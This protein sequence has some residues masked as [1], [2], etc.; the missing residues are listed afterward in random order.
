MWGILKGRE[1]ALDEY[2]L[3]KAPERALFFTLSHWFEN[4]PVAIKQN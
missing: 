1:V 4:P 3:I 2:A